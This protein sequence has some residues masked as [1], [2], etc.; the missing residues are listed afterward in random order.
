MTEPACD[1]C[2]DAGVLEEY[3]SGEEVD[4]PDCRPPLPSDRCVCGKTRRQHETQWPACRGFR[5]AVE[6]GT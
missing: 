3:G 2:G 1:T 5:K 6:S 4:C